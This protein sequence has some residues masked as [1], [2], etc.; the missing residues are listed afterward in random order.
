MVDDGVGRHWV[1]VETEESEVESRCVTPVSDNQG[2]AIES[3][4]QGHANYI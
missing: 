1:A 2:A 4:I 3:I